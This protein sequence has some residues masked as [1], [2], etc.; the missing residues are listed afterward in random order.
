MPSTRSPPLDHPQFTTQSKAPPVT[1]LGLQARSQERGVGGKG[2]KGTLGCAAQHGV[3]FMEPTS[4][5]GEG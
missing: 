5:E 3:G 4:G 1:G 2:A